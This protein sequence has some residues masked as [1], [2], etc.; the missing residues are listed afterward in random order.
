MTK[1][2]IIFKK[3]YDLDKTNKF[4]YLTKQLFELL[5]K[6]YRE[7]GEPGQLAL[8]NA[9]L[10]KIL[11]SSEKGLID[12]RKKLEEADIITYENTGTRNPGTYKFTEVKKVNNFNN[13]FDAATILNSDGSH[14]SYT[15]YTVAG[16][17]E[18][19]YPFVS[20]YSNQ[21]NQY[22]FDFS[23][24]KKVNKEKL[25]D[26]I[27]VFIVG[28]AIVYQLSKKNIDAIRFLMAIGISFAVSF[29]LKTAVDL[30]WPEESSQSSN[31]QKL[32][33]PANPS[34]QQTKSAL[35]AQSSRY[36]I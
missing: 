23:F 33:Q 28:G 20:D 2:E 16:Q 10:C 34:Y 6:I 9:A 8:S 12:A 35:K 25:S 19:S 27:P 18:V 24:L 21:S 36:Q 11:G 4:P 14:S 13:R 15:Y 3:F 29:M 7:N 26:S 5:I 17:P 30:F 1:T 31:Q 32:D 22:N